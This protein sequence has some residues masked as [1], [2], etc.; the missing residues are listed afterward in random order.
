MTLERHHGTWTYDPTAHALYLHLDA[1]GVGPVVHTVEM[2]QAQVM[3]DLDGAGHVIGV[4]IL[5]PWPT[6]ASVTVLP[7]EETPRG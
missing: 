1:P 5:N 3:A 6:I 2:D 4:E 7:E